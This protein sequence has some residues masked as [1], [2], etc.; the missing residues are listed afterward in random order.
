MDEA[1]QALTAF[2]DRTAMTQGP[3]ASPLAARAQLSCQEHQGLQA[4]D[5]LR[6]PNHR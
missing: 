6:P 4:A 2:L 3:V 5:G 1:V